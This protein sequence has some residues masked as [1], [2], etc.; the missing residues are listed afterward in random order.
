M[1]PEQTGG[2]RVAASVVRVRAGSGGLVLP[3][4][5]LRTIR[6]PENPSAREDPAVFDATPTMLIAFAAAVFVLLMLLN[7]VASR[8]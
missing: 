1:M 5:Y 7:V 2:A 8:D 4:W 6:F 3:S